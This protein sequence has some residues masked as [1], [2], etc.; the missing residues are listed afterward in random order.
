MDVH[1]MKKGKRQKEDEE[2]EEGEREIEED[3]YVLLHMS[4]LKILPLSVLPSSTPVL[5]SPPSCPM[6]ILSFSGNHKCLPSRSQHYICCAQP[7]STS[8]RS[9]I[10]RM[11]GDGY[12]P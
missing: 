1:Q 12:K 9:L 4:I 10:A 8:L 6:D 7:S 3:P 5:V 2:E 11:C